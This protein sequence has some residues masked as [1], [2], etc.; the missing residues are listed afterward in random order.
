MISKFRIACAISFVGLLT[1]CNFNK[2]IKTDFITNAIS[3]GNG[4]RCDDISFTINGEKANTTTF[5]RGSEI[6][7]SFN[8]ISGFNKLK[9]FAYPQMSICVVNNKKDTVL[10]QDKIFREGENAIDENPLLIQ[11]YFHTAFP[12]QQLGKF[13]LFI[14]IWDEKGKGTFSHEMPFEVKKNPILKISPKRMQYSEIYLWNQSKKQVVVDPKVDFEDTLILIVEGV[15]GFTSED[16]M[17]YPGLF[18]GMKDQLGRVII[19]ESNAFESLS[20]S[21]VHLSDFE[22]QQMTV[23]IYFK[24]GSLKNPCTIKSELVDIKSDRKISIEGKVVLE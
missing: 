7:F 22:G 16:S 11:A 5:V 3:R 15:K 24:R 13:R 9:G 2:S 4:L 20:Q 12:N 17:V 8:D 19:D 23:Q 6:V 14:K 10:F 1:A 21:G 18:L